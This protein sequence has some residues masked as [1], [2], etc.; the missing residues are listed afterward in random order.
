MMTDDHHNEQNC[1][2]K[3]INYWHVK[4]SLI[5]ECID[6]LHKLSKNN[7]QIFARFAEHLI[8]SWLNVWWF[9]NEW[10][11]LQKQM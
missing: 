9:I 6:D 4:S 2:E 7:S 5:F 10:K 11:K 8:V 3:S 1:V